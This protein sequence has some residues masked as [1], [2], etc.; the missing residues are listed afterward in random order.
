MNAKIKKSNGRTCRARNAM[1][2]RPQNTGDS[3]MRIGLLPVVLA[4]AGLIAGGC[5][6]PHSGSATGGPAAAAEKLPPVIPPPE[7]F[8]AKFRPADQDAGR[9]FYKKYIDVNG[10]PVAASG[11]VTDEAL[12]RT[13][14]IVTHLL[15]ARPDIIQ[16]MIT[17]GTR[18]I[19]IGKDQ[20]Y[21]DMP[22]YRNSP[23]PQYL[24]ERVRGT[25]GVD[26][27]SFGEGKFLYLPLDPYH[28]ERIGVHQICPTH[29]PAPG[30]V[31][32]TSP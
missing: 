14:H 9:K 28:D 24:N 15:A 2:M 5:A 3:G 25:G 13:Y 16:A 19:I 21:T 10:L 20:V 29:P 26:V 1:N 32:P 7:A 6:S 12:Q 17:N 8:F 27:T 11:D 23:N 31:D 30:P 4:L 18:L 22:E